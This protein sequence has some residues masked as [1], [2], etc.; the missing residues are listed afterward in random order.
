MSYVAAFFEAPNLPLSSAM[1]GGAVVVTQFA[2]LQRVSNVAPLNILIAGG[3]IQGCAFAYS[4]HA[5]TVTACKNPQD[6]RP[7]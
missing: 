1:D 4:V 5:T 2:A 7:R 3:G 6:L